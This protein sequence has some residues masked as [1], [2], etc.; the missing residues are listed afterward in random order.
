MD[1]FAGK[2]HTSNIGKGRDGWVAEAM[3]D[4]DGTR[5]LKVATHKTHGGIVTYIQAVKV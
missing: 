5:W 4:L 3:V 1:Q 2:T